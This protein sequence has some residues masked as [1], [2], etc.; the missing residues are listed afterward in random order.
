MRRRTWLAPVRRRLGGAVAGD[1]WDEL[2]EQCAA[3]LSERGLPILH[4]FDLDEFAALVAQQRGR[5]IHLTPMLLHP[6]DA[7]T[8]NGTTMR[9]ATVDYVFYGA[10]LSPLHT[11]HN[12]VHE[13]AHLIWEHRT[14]AP[15]VSWGGD[16]QRLSV[17]AEAEAE[18]M[19]AVVLS[20]C[21]SP[22]GSWQARDSLR[23]G[24]DRLGS[25]LLW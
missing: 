6:D 16:A 9:S 14:V 12:A 7:M 13:F 1:D 15:L 11:T 5:P 23:D 4:P 10:T 25:T 3:M 8:C 19:A 22:S 18:A 17:Q 20:Q 24:A 21:E 2:I